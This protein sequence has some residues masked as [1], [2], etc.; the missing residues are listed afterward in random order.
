[1]AKK[2]YT[3][4]AGESLSIIA[5]DVLGDMSRWPEIAYINSIEPPYLIKTGQVILLPN[6]G[7]PLQVVI[8]VK[9]GAAVTKEAGIT[10][11]PVTVSVLIVAAVAFLLWDRK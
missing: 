7:E 3:V 10:F 1:M 8:P 11:T 6:D 9:P 4:K 2:L 5:R